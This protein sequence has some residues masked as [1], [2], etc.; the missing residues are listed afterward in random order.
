MDSMELGALLKVNKHCRE[1][2]RRLILYAPRPKVR[3]LLETCR[4]IEYFD[5]AYSPEEV[6]ALLKAVSDHIV[7]SA[8]Y[9]EEALTLALPME[10]TA[11]TLP[12]FKEQSE[13]L[14]HELKQ[15][16]MLKSIRIDATRLDFIDS[17]GLGFLAGLKKQAQVEDIVMTIENMGKKPRRVFEIARVDEILLE[18]ELVA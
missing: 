1:K 12:E 5:I 15:Q 6:T 10:L 11:A 14:H 9:E 3:R 17:S 4:L 8:V 18:P 7:G 13:Q 2:G 16:G